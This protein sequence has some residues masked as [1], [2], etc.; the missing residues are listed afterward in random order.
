MFIQDFLFFLI[1]YKTMYDNHKNLKKWL[2]KTFL[3]LIIKQCN[4]ECDITII[5]TCQFCFTF[6]IFFK[7]K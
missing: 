4:F 1:K 5:R 3:K 6:W 2:N 7:I